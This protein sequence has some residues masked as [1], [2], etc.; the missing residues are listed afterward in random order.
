MRVLTSD[1][2]IITCHHCRSQLLYTLEDIKHET[3][4]R[5]NYYG[6]NRDAFVEYQF[7]ICPCCQMSQNID[8]KFKEVDH[9]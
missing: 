6:R 4:I 8:I 3:V 1:E 2:H 5:P 9:K 7:I